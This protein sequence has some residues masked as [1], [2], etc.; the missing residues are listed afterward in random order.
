MLDAASPGIVNYGNES[1]VEIVSTLSNFNIS[2]IRKRKKK[3]ERYVYKRIHSL[4]ETRKA[5]EKYFIMENSFKRMKRWS[6]SLNA[7]TINDF[8]HDFTIN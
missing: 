5:L 1:C 2:I 3:R 7:L 8:C 6:R 4:R